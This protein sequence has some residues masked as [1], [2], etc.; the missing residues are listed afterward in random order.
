MKSKKYSVSSDSTKRFL[1]CFSFML[2]GLKVVHAHGVGSKIA[3]NQLSDNR[4]KS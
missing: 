3:Q 4:G 2:G 1:F